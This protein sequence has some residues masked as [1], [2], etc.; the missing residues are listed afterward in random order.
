MYV[1]TSK[2]KKDSGHVDGRFRDVSRVS[3]CYVLYL[4]TLGA[5][6]LGTYVHTPNARVADEPPLPRLH[7]VRDRSAFCFVSS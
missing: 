5:K 1:Q 7:I 6:C 3:V 4:G 2:V